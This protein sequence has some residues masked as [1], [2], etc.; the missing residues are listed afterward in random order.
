[1]KDKDSNE[2]QKRGF[3]ERTKPLGVAALGF[4]TVTFLLTQGD[5]GG[6][7]FH[8]PPQAIG[9][10]GLSGSTTSTSATTI[11]QYVP[12]T[13]IDRVYEARI[14]PDRAKVAQRGEPSPKQVPPIPRST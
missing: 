3:I 11:F 1:M 5:V 14:A 7:R 12:D 13:I 2:E 6:E 8:L 9:A 4:T 10:L